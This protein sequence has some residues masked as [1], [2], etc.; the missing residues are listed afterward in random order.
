MDSSSS[1]PSHPPRHKLRLAIGGVIIALAI[2]FGWHHLAQFHHPAWGFTRLLQISPSWSEKAVPEVRAT[3]TYIYREEAGYD[4][5]F[6]AQ[7]ALR[8][9]LQDATLDTALD[10]PSMR[11]R[12]ILTSWIAT[13][14]G[15]GDPA[16]TLNT[17]AWLNVVAWIAL[18]IMLC[19]LLPP[20]NAHH[21]VA[22]IGVMFSA[23]VTASVAYALTDLPALLFL[24]AGVLALQ[25]QRSKTAAGWFAAACLSRETSLLA[26]LTLF[27][28]ATWRERIMRGLLLT[29]PVAVWFAYVSYR[30]PAAGNSL[31]NFALPFTAL[32]E[33]LLTTFSAVI[34]R[35]ADGLAWAGFGAILAIVVQAAWLIIRPQPRNP[36][37]QL[38]IGYVVLLALL[39]PPTFDGFPG[40]VTRILLPLHLAFVMLTPRT[41]AGLV[42]IIVGSLS[43]FTGGYMLSLSAINTKELNHANPPAGPIIAEIQEG[44]YGV[45]YS[46]KHTWSWCAGNGRLLVRRFEFS[47]PPAPAALRFRLVSELGCEVTI[48]HAGDL[49]WQGYSPPGGVIVELDQIPLD[50][51]GRALLKFSTD[52]PVRREPGTDRRLAFAIHNLEFIPDQ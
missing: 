37:W 41:R 18:G 50:E 51:T 22:W 7:L 46:R 35:P 3:E 47:P 36:W 17:Y 40:A 12:R 27:Q 6:Y 5:Q 28:L 31:E 4:G 1:S 20:T 14:A 10:I 16:R 15:W 33:K 52:D 45:E 9:T 49:L 44:W 30:F 21:V 34:A 43:I 11:A 24:M 32:T 13:V 19:R 48:H 39:G 42:L 8:P 38:G 29:I 2:S 25:K 26:G 23:G